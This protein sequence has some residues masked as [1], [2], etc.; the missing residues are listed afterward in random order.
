MSVVLEGCFRGGHKLDLAFAGMV[1]G[2][3]G[4][5]RSVVAA[6]V[7]LVVISGYQNAVAKIQN[8]GEA[9]LKVLRGA[10][11][12]KPAGVCLRCDILVHVVSSCFRDLAPFVVYIYHS[13]SLK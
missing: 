2:G 4:V 3:K 13:E 10:C 12:G 1:V 7:G 11:S 5:N 9:H 8:R 6:A